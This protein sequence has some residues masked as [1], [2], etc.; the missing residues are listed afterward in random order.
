MRNAHTREGFRYDA[1]HTADSNNPDPETTKDSLRAPTPCRNGPLKF[2]MKRRDWTKAI[3]KC[4]A[5]L[6]TNYAHRVA[7]RHG[8]FPGRLLIP[9]P[10]T[11]GAVGADRHA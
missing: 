8:I 6:F 3:V 1:P 9:Y 5:K 2:F 11:P 7:P 4:N 10:C